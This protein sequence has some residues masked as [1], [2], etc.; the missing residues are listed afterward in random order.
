MKSVMVLFVAGLFV[1]GIGQISFS[2][3]NYPSTPKPAQP[4]PSVQTQAGD[5]KTELKTAITHAGFAGGG[6][7]LG[8][9]QQHLGHTLN[10]IEG[11]KGRNFNQSWGHVCQGQ[12]NGILVDL[13]AAQGGAGFMLV[14][15]QADSLALAGVKSKDL[16]EARNAA[17]GLGA[18]LTVVADNLK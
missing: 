16:A 10:C 7:A 6:D 11:T 15:G 8:S 9:V 4:A 14:A 13:K 5:V 1:L 17:K 18:L 12:G 3:Y 2:Q